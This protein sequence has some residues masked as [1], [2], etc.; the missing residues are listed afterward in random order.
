[1]SDLVG[2]TQTDFLASRLTVLQDKPVHTHLYFLVIL[3]NANFVLLIVPS[4]YFC[5][6]S[7]CFM[8]WCLN[9]FCAVGAL[10]MFSYF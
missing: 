3:F 8:S 10:C 2:T 9:F 5:G 4:R 6:G 1:M 7:F